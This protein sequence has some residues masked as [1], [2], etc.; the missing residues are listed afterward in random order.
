MYEVQS[1]SSFHLAQLLLTGVFGVEKDHLLEWDAHE[2]SQLSGFTDGFRVESFRREFELS[3]ALRDVVCERSHLTRPRS[4]NG[5]EYDPMQG[6]T[7][8]TIEG[9]VISSTIPCDD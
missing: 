7:S 9:L 6:A 4:D 3:V 5:F 1:T 8:P 2:R